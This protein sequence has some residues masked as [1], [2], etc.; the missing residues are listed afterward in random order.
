MRA[1]GVFVLTTALALAVRPA[2]AQPEGDFEISVDDCPPDLS[3]RLPSVVRLE[4]RVLLRERAVAS[5][6]VQRIGVR[7]DGDVVRID[8]TAGGTIRFSVIDSRAI[9]PEH[10]ARALGLAAGELI[11]ALWSEQ[12]GRGAPPASAA[13][14]VPTPTDS[15]QSSPAPEHPGSVAIGGV[16]TRTGR[17]AALLFGGR[18]EMALRLGPLFTPVLSLDAAWGHADADPATVS[19]RSVSA[20]AHLLVGRSPGRLSWGIG[21][22]AHA[23]WARLDGKPS[24][25]SGLEARS[26][27]AAWA[28][29]A[30]RA[31]L[32]CLLG[33]GPGL[34]P[35]A[36]MEG[37]AGLVLLPVRGTQDGGRRV[38]SLDGPWLSLAL[39]VGA[40][41]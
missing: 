28:G 5:P 20:A 25:E 16:V 14:E 29:L 32:A 13:P 8:A 12:Q 34:V 24:A 9:A 37:D 3:E 19:V 21:P 36:A 35:F 39:S 17:P 30:L 27:S 7:C 10:R 23:G 1:L 2:H 6:F 31:R 41:F 26:L 11:D 22:G 40:S 15:V 38:F 4:V 33:S 18:A